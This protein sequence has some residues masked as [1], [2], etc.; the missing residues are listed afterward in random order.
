MSSLVV[1]VGVV[2]ADEDNH[3]AWERKQVEIDDITNM[4]EDQI[5]VAAIRLAEKAFPAIHYFVFDFD[6]NEV[7]CYEEDIELEMDMDFD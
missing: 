1:D 5:A 4:S 3:G 6:A 7:I 2:Y